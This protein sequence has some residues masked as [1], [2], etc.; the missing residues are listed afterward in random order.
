MLSDLTRDGMLERRS[1]A[2]VVRD[3][4]RLELLV[5]DVRGGA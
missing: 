1:D 2:L 4:P 3:L 5:E